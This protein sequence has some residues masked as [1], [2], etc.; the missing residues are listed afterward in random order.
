MALGK[1]V[2]FLG[3]GN[4]ATAMIQGLL[5]RGTVAKEEVLVSE[6]VAALRDGLAA[7]FGVRTT[8]NN[9]EGVREADVIILAVKPQVLVGVLGEIAPAVT[10]EKLVISIAAGIPLDTLAGALPVGTRLVRTMPNTPALVG[11]GATGVSAGV[12]AT[13]TDLEL[14]RTLF[15]SVGLS[16]VVP[17]SLLDAVTGLSGS[18]PAY[19]FLFIEALAD[20]GVR[21]GLPRDAALK[22]AAQTVL[23]SARMVLETGKHPGEL[24]DMVT[25]PGGTTIAGVH[26]LESKGFRAAAIDAV[27]AATDRSAELGRLASKK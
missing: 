15:D 7:R 19:V 12:T 2:L 6:P 1:T 24:K 21:S 5:A 18:G 27:K 11:A 9:L 10:S 14:A 8:T 20:G 16:V 17:E 22:L 3:G 25:S 4:M 13:P 26:A 23:G